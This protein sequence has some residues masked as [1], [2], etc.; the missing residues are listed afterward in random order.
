LTEEAGV[1]P[2]NAYCT[3]NPDS[4]KVIPGVYQRLIGRPAL[5]PAVVAADDNI[6]RDHLRGREIRPVE[7]SGVNPS[8]RMDRSPD[9]RAV[10]AGGRASARDGKAGSRKAR[11]RRRGRGVLRLINMRRPRRSQLIVAADVHPIRPG[12][13]AGV[14]YS[15]HPRL[16]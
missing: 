4:G 9:G 6:A 15:L 2:W 5:A 8:A 7:I 3:S 14:G 1:P 12:C 11:R 16:I 10:L 13:N